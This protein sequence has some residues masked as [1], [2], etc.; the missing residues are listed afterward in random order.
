MIKYL[1]HSEIDKKKWDACIKESFNGMVYASSWYLDIVGFEWEALIENDMK[2]F[3][4]WYM[5]VNG[6]FIIYISRF[7]PS[8]WV[9]FPKAFYHPN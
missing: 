8:N 2:V 1:H 6:A 4:R 7:L 9:F 3:F 5:E